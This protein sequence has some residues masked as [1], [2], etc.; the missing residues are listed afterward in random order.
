MVPI[1]ATVQH[2]PQTFVITVVARL[3]TLRTVW[4]LASKMLYTQTGSAMA[5]VTMVRTCLQIT[6]TADQKALLSGST[7]MN[8]IVTM[9]TVRVVVVVVIQ[10]ALAVLVLIVQ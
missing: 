2:V 4:A 9:V 6:V 1:R 3:D 10:P 5:T 7:V 8:S